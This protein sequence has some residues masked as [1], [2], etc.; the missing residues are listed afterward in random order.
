M[1]KSPLVIQN[2]KVDMKKIVIYFHGYDSSASSGKTEQL[3]AAGF[4]TY[5]WDIDID[6]SVSI[7]YLEEQILDMILDH[8]N[9]EIE[10]FFVGTSLGG[11][12]A[13]KLAELFNSEN[14]F[15]VNPSYNPSESL[16]KYGEP[17]SICEKYH[18][19]EFKNYHTIY[20]GAEDTVID[21]TDVDFN[22]AD[23]SIVGGADHRF[24]DYFYR[25]IED[26]T[27]A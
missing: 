16:K 7:P 13:A 17:L 27:P 26:L 9:E 22:G 15:L 4:E 21:F 8:V 10:L 11:W 5:S 12:Y 14:V 3:K 2:T 23:F 24:A 18:D 6:P 19:L 25:V 1:R 20:I